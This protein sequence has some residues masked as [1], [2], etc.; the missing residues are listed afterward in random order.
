MAL[1]TEIPSDI[2][3]TWRLKIRVIVFLKG[4]F[5]R[6]AFKRPFLVKSFLFTLSVLNCH[7][8]DSLSDKL[9]GL[10]IH[11]LLAPFARRGQRCIAGMLVPPE[12]TVLGTAIRAA[13]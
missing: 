8:R 2:C 11:D 6:P 12:V 13:L 1:A 5:L 3:Y 4:H 7:Y 10:F 9:D